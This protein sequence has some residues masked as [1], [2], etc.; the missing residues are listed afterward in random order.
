MSD[1]VSGKTA[2]LLINMGSPDAPSPAAVKTYLRQFLSDRRVVPRSGLLWWLILHGL[3]LT[4]RPKKSAARYERIWSKEGAPLKVHT[5]KQAKLLKGLLGQRGHTLLI[6]WAMRY[7]RPSLPETLTQLEKEGA[8]RIVL[9]PLYPQYAVSTTASAL[10][11]VAA[12][13]AK[14]A[15][16]PEVR[17]VD[18]FFQDE[19][20]LAALEQTVR[21]HWQHTSLPDADYC[22]LISFHGQPKNTL[23]AGDPY[24]EECRTTGRLLA[25]RLNLPPERYR[26]A[27][28]S[29]FGRG[30]WLGPDTAEVLR[31]LGRAGRRVDVICPGFVADCLETLEEIAIEG[32]ATFLAAG[33]SLFHYIPA[34]NEHPL[35]IEA[36]AGLVETQLRSWPADPANCP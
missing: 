33:G 26:I 27:F 35:W 23:G 11:E 30:E 19:G 8:T 20:Y 32:K 10:D 28:Q 24:E 18:S 34:L 3:I 22:L 2:V 1:S 36:L 12:W 16:P 31:E 29:R 21:T 7:G 13:L 6:R 15:N 17:T 5:E 25:E 14:T 9:L 4:T